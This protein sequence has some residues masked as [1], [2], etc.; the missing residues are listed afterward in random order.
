MD[1]ER[2]AINAELR[3]NAACETVAS[4][5]DIHRPPAPKARNSARRCRVGCIAIPAVPPT[6][7]R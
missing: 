5:V 7:A 1:G 3:T 6:P 4:Y 2:E